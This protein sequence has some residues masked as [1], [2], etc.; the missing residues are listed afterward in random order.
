MIGSYIFITPSIIVILH[1]NIHKISYFKPVWISSFGAYKINFLRWKRYILEVSSKED[2]LLKVIWACYKKKQLIWHALPPLICWIF[3]SSPHLSKILDFQFW[4]IITYL[5]TTGCK[6]PFC[7]FKK[8]IYKL[9]PRKNCTWPFAKEMGEALKVKITIHS[10]TRNQ[11][12]MFHSP[13]LKCIH[14][15]CCQNH[16][17]HILCYP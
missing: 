15:V 7:F 10:K 9:I 8:A 2:S 13:N 11:K 6:T 12:F 5:V 14:S 1:Q 17:P 16:A 3:Y 4:C